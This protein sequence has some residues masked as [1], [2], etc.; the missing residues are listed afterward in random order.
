MYNIVGSI[1]LLC[2]GQY[3]V[4]FSPPDTDPWPSS[5]ESFEQTATTFMRSAMPA[6]VHHKWVW[7]LLTVPPRSRGQGGSLDPHPRLLLLL[8]SSVF[9]SAL[10]T[11]S[12][13]DRG[14]GGVS[15]HKLRMH[16][17]KAPSMWLWGSRHPSRGKTFQCAAG[18]AATSLPVTLIHVLWVSQG[19]QFGL[20]LLLVPWRPH[21]A[22]LRFFSFLSFWCEQL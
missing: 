18:E 13:E 15:V 9:H 16:K 3:W 6:D 19:A 4:H 22:V 17:E 10:I 2:D 5:S 20:V 8:Q 12:R 1:H 7:G 11:Q 14:M 21:Q